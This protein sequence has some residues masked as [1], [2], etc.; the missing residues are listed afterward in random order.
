MTTQTDMP[1]N[2]QWLI[3]AA[4]ILA[5]VAILVVLGRHYF[6]EQSPSLAQELD[7]DKHP[8]PTWVIE[9]ARKC[10]GDISQLEPA[11]QAKIRASYPGQGAKAIVAAAYA[12][13]P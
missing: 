11:E 12:T 1:A 8:I 9:D 2:R 7:L 6:T 10:K 13:Q 4:A 5:L 3:L